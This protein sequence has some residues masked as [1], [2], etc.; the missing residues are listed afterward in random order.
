[1]PA[2]FNVTRLCCPLVAARRY[3]R[4]RC[5]RYM[6]KPADRLCYFNVSPCYL[7]F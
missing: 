2:F 6:V 5:V 4:S 7:I 1:M 3:R